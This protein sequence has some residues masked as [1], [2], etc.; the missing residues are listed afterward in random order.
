MFCRRLLSVW[1]SQSLTG[2]RCCFEP[3]VFMNEAIKLSQSTVICSA[4]RLTSRGLTLLLAGMCAVPIATIAMLFYY[5]PPVHVG[6]LQASISAEGLP[7]GSFYDLPYDQRTAVPDGVLV[8]QNDSEQE[9]THL[10]IQINKHYQV[11]DHQ[12][13]P[14]GGV[15]RYRLDRFVS[16][17]GA[18]FQLRINPLRSVRIYARRPTKDRATFFTE[19][20]YRSVY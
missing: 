1:T 6:E 13:I 11:Y 14:P 3:V 12:P 18:L 9:W 4:P 15:R 16:R 7:P 19:F 17:T 5:M 10:N 2:E 20:D 8:V